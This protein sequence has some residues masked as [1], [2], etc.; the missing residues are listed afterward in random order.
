MLTVVILAKNEEEHI[1]RAI[2]SAAF[3]DHIL[4]VDNGSTDKTAAIARRHKAT[5]ITDDTDRDF[6]T[7][8]N[9]ALKHA[10]TDWVFFLDADEQIGDMLAQNLKAVT[11]YTDNPYDAYYVRRID[12]FWG[13]QMRFGETL[14]ART[15]GICRL[16]K[17]SS[18]TH[19]IGRVHECPTIPNRAA[20]RLEGAI[21]HTPH[22]TIASFLQHVN[23]YSSIRAEELARDA[24]PD[25]LSLYV[26]LF[27]YPPLKFLYTYVLLGGFLDGMPGFVY[28]FMM[29]FHSFLVRAKWYQ[30]SVLMKRRP[31]SPT[32]S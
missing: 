23:F 7:L 19:W 21:I 31:I 26:P 12:V 8:R 30:M 10:K 17:K 32:N 15:A 2:E 11:G 27:V 20:A 16:V 28:S 1:A 4:V 13:H 5:I 18:G 14:Q 9:N 24:T 6:A 3:A 25:P 22:Q 29:S